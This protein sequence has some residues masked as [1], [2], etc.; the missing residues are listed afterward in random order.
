MIILSQ[1]SKVYP[2]RES[3]LDGVSLKIAQGEFVFV[4]GSS[5]AG[6]STLLKLILGSERASSGTVSVLG[7]DMMTLTV[8]ERANL[9]RS[10]GVVFQDYKLLPRRSV[11]DNVILPLA[12]AGVGMDAARDQGK[13]LLDLVG[14]AHRIDAVPTALSGGE[15]QRVAVA[16]A[17]IH[18]PRLVIADEPTGNL[19]VEMTRV[20]FDLLSVARQVGVTVLAAT[21]NLSVIEELGQR[22]IVL[23]RGKIVGD[24]SRSVGTL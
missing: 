15:Q 23:E 1:V 12:I 9:R 14:M 16:R 3:A 7:N 18:H 17:L 11:L 19:D 20:V 22:A 5:G 10:I 4:A 8:R 6:K 24:F 21:H 2:P 13:K